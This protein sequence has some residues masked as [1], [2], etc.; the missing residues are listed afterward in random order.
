MVFLALMPLAVGAQEQVPPEE[1]LDSTY[2]DIEERMLLFADE[3]NQLYALSRFQMNIDVEMPLTPS[4]LDV[5]S[6]RL[7]SLVN[8]INSFS[9]RW[10]TYSQAQQVYIADN[11]SLLNKVA[12]IQQMQQTVT[13]TIAARQKQFE[14]TFNNCINKHYN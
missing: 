2:V 7:N 9:V 3:L 8:A 14:H 1:E 10:N 4:L 11:D 6:G 13:D 12:Q 5:V